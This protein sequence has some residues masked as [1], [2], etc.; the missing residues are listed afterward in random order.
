[1]RKNRKKTEAERIYFAIFG[2]GLPEILEERFAGAARKIEG[3]YSAA[4]KDDY[5]RWMERVSDLEA[6]EYA[7]RFRGRLGILSDK[8]KAMVYLAETLPENYSRFINERDNLIKGYWLCAIG[9]FSSIWKLFKG[10]MILSF[11]KP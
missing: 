7:A 9:T 5:G 10:M 8:F 1:M 2:E 4:E 11:K 3:N 6:L